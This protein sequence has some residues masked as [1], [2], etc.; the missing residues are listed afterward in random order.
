MES[1][2]KPA[3]LFSSGGSQAVRLPAE[4]RFSG[5]EV[6]YVRR[7]AAGEVVLSS[8]PPRPYAHFMAVR[9]QLGPV[10]EE[11]LGPAE[12]AQGSST[13]DPFAAPDGRASPRRKR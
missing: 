10:P 8:Q 9:D 12:R 3:K 1:V 11:F 4:F 6:V 13:R 7:N 5:V 2:S